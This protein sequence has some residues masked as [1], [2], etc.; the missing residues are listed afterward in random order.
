[1]K[2]IRTASLLLLVLPLASCGNKGPLL[3]APEPQAAPEMPA[4]P[5]PAAPAST[6][7]APGVS[8]GEGASVELRDDA[9]DS[10]DD[11][12]ATPPPTEGNNGTLGKPR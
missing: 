10:H 8:V 11:A 12:D 6:M 4:E 2:L 7:P 3:L 5:M 9:L 1:M